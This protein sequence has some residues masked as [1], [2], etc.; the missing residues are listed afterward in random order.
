MQLGTAWVLMLLACFVVS[1]I[2]IESMGMGEEEDF[3]EISLLHSQIRD[4]ALKV[5][6]D[7]S[8]EE[9]EIHIYDLN[10]M[11]FL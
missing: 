9:G 5:K 2:D 4:R 1:Q 6:H 11:H 8:S 3:S 10:S 7:F